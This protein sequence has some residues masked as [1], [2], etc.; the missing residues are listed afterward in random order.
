MDFARSMAIELAGIALMFGCSFVELPLTS[1][2]TG[3][4]SEIDWGNAQTSICGCDSYR[5]LVDDTY[6]DFDGPTKPAG[7]PPYGGQTVQV[8]YLDLTFGEEVLAVTAGPGLPGSVTYVTPAGQRFASHKAVSAAALAGLL[9]GLVLTVVGAVLV[10]RTIRRLGA[11]HGAVSTMLA[12]LSV[13]GIMP[14]LATNGPM[15]GLTIFIPISALVGIVS[16]L[17]VIGTGIAGFR[18]QPSGFSRYPL[19]LVSMLTVVLIGMFINM[20]SRAMF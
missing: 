19:A 5:I 6:F 8:E 4:A 7:P 17:I 20:L 13:L 14:F 3:T 16:T 15:R 12:P 18:E 10:V 11:V 9:L 1:S 2:A